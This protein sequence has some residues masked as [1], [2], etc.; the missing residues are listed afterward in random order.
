MFLWKAGELLSSHPRKQY[1]LHL[2]TLHK[3]A[4]QKVINK[5]VEQTFSRAWEFP[6]GNFVKRHIQMASPIFMKALKAEDRIKLQT[7]HKYAF[8]YTKSKRK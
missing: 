7:T 5:A 1:S 8:L 4:F 2:Y 6:T 3:A